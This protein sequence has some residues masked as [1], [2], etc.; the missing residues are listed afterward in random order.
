MTDAFGVEIREDVD[1]KQSSTPLGDSI[2][3]CRNLVGKNKGKDRGGSIISRN[4]Q[5]KHPDNKRKK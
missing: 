5:G 1:L 3:S 4:R 2:I